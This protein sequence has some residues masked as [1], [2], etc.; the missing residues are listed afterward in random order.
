MG[1]RRGGRGAL[2]PW[3]LTFSAK[4]VVFFVLSG[5]NQISSLLPPSGKI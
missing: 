5:K 3:I 4:K 2:S 1:V